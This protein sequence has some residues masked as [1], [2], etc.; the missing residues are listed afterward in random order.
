M[1]EIWKIIPGYGGFYKISN[2]GR[3]KRL[4]TKYSP[5]ERVLKWG[6]GRGYVL[7]T[8]SKYAEKKRII[9]HRMVARLFVPN[10][11]K[12]PCV[13]HKDDDKGNPR[14]DNLFWGTQ[15]DNIRDCHRKGRAHNNLPKMKGKNH[16]MYGKHHSY[17]SKK[18]MAS[19]NTIHTEKMLIKLLVDYKKGV[20][21]SE[22]CKKYKVA[23]SLVSILINK[24]TFT[25][26]RLNKLMALK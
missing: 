22:L 5:K 26:K 13:L 24:K 19:K 23:S 9:V 10:P 2:F 20:K 25:A 12:Y 15:S 4:I 1:T 7:A 21:Q 11:K 8:L 3:V 14:C 17:E 18:K 16:P 6:Y